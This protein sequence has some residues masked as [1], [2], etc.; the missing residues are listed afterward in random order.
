MTERSL[1]AVYQAHVRRDSASIDAEDLLALS[2]A[3][4]AIDPETLERL[5][6][7][8]DAL[9]LCGIAR[10][11]SPWSAAV[12][13]DV[14]RLRPREIVGAGRVRNWGWMSLAAAAGLAVCVVGLRQREPNDGRMQIA[15]KTTAASSE[16]AVPDMLFADPEGSMIAVLHV[17]PSDS[18]FTDN[19][20]G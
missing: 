6:R 11:S 7:S 16:V 13:E 10:S 15:A 1:S 12:A 5:L 4:D 14:G 9:A 3:A 17:E 18:I 19:L 2:D 20:D 8:P